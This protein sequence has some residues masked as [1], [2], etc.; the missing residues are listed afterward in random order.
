[1]IGSIIIRT[2]ATVRGQHR[3]AVP[4]VPRPID[5]YTDWKNK[6]LNID[7]Q[8]PTNNYPWQWKKTK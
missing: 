6:V 3:G 8:V 4:S 2:G 1:M 5:R 7:E